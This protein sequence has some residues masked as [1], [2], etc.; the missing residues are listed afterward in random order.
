MK[1]RGCT[2]KFMLA[3]GV[4][5]GFVVLPFVV[6]L[7]NAIITGGW[8]VLWLI[9]S[10][11]LGLPATIFTYLG[12]REPPERPVRID[13]TLERRVLQLAAANDGEL[14][15]SQLAL[16]SQLRIEDCQEVL[17]Y[18]ETAG[19]ARSYVGDQGEFRY[20]F[21]ELQESMADDD[22]MRRLE[23]EDPRSVLDF[24]L[25]DID[26]DAKDEAEVWEEG[27]INRDG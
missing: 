8:V 13:E 17:E 14:T 6:L 22:F 24:D 10:V 7:I 21:P 18:F 25:S 9:V 19:V 27:P 26:K 20:L 12:L 15:P 11:M 4:V 5:L 2:Q 23:Q 3:L 1:P 16:N